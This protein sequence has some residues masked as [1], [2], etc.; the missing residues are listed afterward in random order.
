MAQEPGPVLEA[1]E[2][3]TVQPDAV[4]LF[5]GHSGWGPGQLEAE[6]GESSWLV[7]APNANMILH[8]APGIGVWREALRGLGP[9]AAGLAHLPPDISWN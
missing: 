8:C 6:L 4:R 1:L 9:S 3:G 2:K 5:E 7:G